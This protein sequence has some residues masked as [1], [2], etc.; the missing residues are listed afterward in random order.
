MAKIT[1]AYETEYNV[2][3][4]V[5]FKKYDYL[6]SGIIEGFH[7]DD[8]TFWF[9]MRTSKNFVYTYSNGGDI[10]E[11]NIVCKLP[12]DMAEKCRKMILE[13]EDNEDE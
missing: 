5:L 9:N 3:D 12:D 6:L 4:V 13:I 1:I 10:P 7:I 8:R 11:F 2:G